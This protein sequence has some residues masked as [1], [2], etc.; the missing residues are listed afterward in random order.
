ER[1]RKPSGDEFQNRAT[2]P[3]TFAKIALKGF[4]KPDEILFNRG[5][6]EAVIAFERGALGGGQHS[7]FCAERGGDD[8][9]GN[10]TDGCEYQNRNADQGRDEGDEALCEVAEHEVWC[11]RWQMGE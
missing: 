4:A 9:A 5:F 6:I 7:G 10:E 3:D 11:N 8:V 2:M 1:K